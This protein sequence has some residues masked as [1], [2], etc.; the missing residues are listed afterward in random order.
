MTTYVPRPL[1][2][3]GLPGRPRYAAATVARA[4]VDRILPAPVVFRW[5]NLAGN[6][7]GF[8]VLTGP[9]VRDAVPTFVIGTGEDDYRAATVTDSPAGVALSRDPDPASGACDEPELVYVWQTWA[10]MVNDPDL[11]GMLAAS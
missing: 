11:P 4:L 9:N 3:D 8:V 2:P 1:P 6:V 7:G 5:D 10:D